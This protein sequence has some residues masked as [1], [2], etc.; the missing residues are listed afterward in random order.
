MVHSPR[1]G[2]KITSNRPS[3]QSRKSALLRRGNRIKAAPSGLEEVAAPF[4]RAYLTN[5]GAAPSGFEEVASP[6]RPPR[7]RQEFWGWALAAS[8][9]LKPM[10]TFGFCPSDHFTL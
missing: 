3:E 5:F 6:F 8:F 4:R 10:H 1:N 7:L 9:P 2:V